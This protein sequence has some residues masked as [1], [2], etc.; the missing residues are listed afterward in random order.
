M[1]R[2]AREEVRRAILDYNGNIAAA[3]DRLGVSRDVILRALAGIAVAA[4]LSDGRPL[5]PPRHDLVPPDGK[6]VAC[7]VS[8]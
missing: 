7:G 3:A 1:Y 8:K 5:G 4:I 2:L 6:I